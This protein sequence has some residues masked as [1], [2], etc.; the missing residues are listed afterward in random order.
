MSQKANLR[1]LFGLSDD[2]VKK[3]ISD[4]TFA[5][6]AADQKKTIIKRPDILKACDLDKK[7]DKRLHD[8]VI[9]QAAKHLLDTFGIELTELK[10]SSQY[11]LVNK[12]TEHSGRDFL[13]WS[14]KENA[15]TGLTF[16][17]LGLIMMSND[18]VTEEVLFKFLKSLGLYEDGPGGKNTKAS[19]SDCISE[20]FDGD[21]KLFIN[22]TLVTKQH[23]LDRTEFT[24]MN[25]EKVYEYSWG[26]RAHI[27]VKPSDV[28]KMV[29]D[30]YECDGTMFREQMDKIKAD[31]KLDDEFFNFQAQ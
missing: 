20:F 6:L 24:N 4:A 16:L 26:Q 27:E 19:E 21:T 15:R 13:K 11:I 22:N 10:K 12:L 25:E 30:V 2:D 17:I 29:C 23:Y 18:K 1:E 31:E 5:F 28:F 8:Y 3:M 14:D 9:A 7:K